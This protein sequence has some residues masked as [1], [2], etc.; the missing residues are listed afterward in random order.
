ME[1]GRETEMGRDDGVF[2][3]LDHTNREGLTLTASAWDCQGR[4]LNTHC[5]AVKETQTDQ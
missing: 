5:L 1:V 3:C 4:D 2:T